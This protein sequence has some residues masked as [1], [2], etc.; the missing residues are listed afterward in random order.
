MAKQIVGVILKPS[1]CDPSSVFG[2]ELAHISSQPLREFVVSC[3]YTAPAYFW[4]APASSSGKHHPRWAN[5]AGGL[6]RHTKAAVWVALELL[7]AY[8]ELQPERNY[9]VAALLLHDTVKFGFNGQATVKEHPLLPREYYAE[10][11]EILGDEEYEK[12]MGLIETHMGVWG[13]D[14]VDLS[15]SPGRLS[16]AELVHLADYIASRQWNGMYTP[17]GRLRR[18]KERPIEEA[19]SGPE[20]LPKDWQLGVGFG[21]IQLRIEGKLVWNTISERHG[22]KTVAWLEKKFA[23]ELRNAEYATLWFNAPLSDRLYEYDRE[24]GLWYLVA[25]GPGFA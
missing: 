22:N 9:I 12:V 17:D 2:E 8:P 7:E 5:G 20:I 1:F 18:M 21:E 6:V 25:E 24:D 10:H 14:G 19:R 16:A 13:P 4:R 23:K 11:K 15:P 3:L